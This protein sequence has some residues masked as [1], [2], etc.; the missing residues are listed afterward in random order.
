MNSGPTL[1]SGS[2]GPD[3]KRVQRIMV[4]IKTLDFSGI[5]GTFGPQTEAAV[6]SFQQSSG[7]TVDGVVG[8]L[9]W[10]AMPADPDTPQLASGSTGSEVSAV[11]QVLM[12]AGLYTGTVD[13]DFGSLTEA[14]VKAY[15]TQRGIAADGIIGDQTWWVPAGAAGATLA[16]LAG[17][18][19]A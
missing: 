3:V 18:T 8:P 6:K 12:N 5:D 19:T 4:M 7:L 17:L 15:Q 11:Q 9:T 2:T 16:S 14:A 1:S 10:Q 13:G